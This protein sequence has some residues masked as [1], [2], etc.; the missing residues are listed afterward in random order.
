MAR[1]ISSGAQLAPTRSSASQPGYHVSLTTS[2]R[3]VV[4]LVFNRSSFGEARENSTRA[5]IPV[6]TSSDVARVAGVSRATVSYVLNN[7]GAVRISDPTRRRVHQAAR[8]LGYVPHAAARSLRAG[9]SRMVLMPAPTE[10]R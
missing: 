6:P 7:T 8:D 4:V 9:H 10:P 1:W 2:N 5:G 3:R